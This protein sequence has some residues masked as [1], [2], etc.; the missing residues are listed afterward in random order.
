[1]Y[2]TYALISCTILSNFFTLLCSPLS[3]SF[4]PKFIR[5][6]MTMNLIY[7]LTS[8]NEVKLLFG[9]FGLVLLLFWVAFNH[10]I[11]SEYLAESVVTL[12][13]DWKL[14]V[15]LPEHTVR[16]IKMRR[17]GSGQSVLDFKQRAE[18][19]YI[20]QNLCRSEWTDN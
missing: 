16:C 12:H 17:G 2:I 9:L 10:M 1:M 19:L 20:F 3:T 11:I 8:F 13:L 4:T 6:W 14:R 5:L 15:R 18:L 7:F